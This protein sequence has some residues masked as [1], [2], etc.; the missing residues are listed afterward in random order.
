[1]KNTKAS[2]PPARRQAS[3]SLD[4]VMAY[5][6]VYA[7]YGEAKVR[8]ITIRRATFTACSSWYVTDDLIEPLVPEVW[9][10]QNF[11]EMD[12]D[13]SISFLPRCQ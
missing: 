3:F 10:G 8:I 2:I 6:G 12:E 5:P 4:H 1:M 9:A 11:L 7:P 13:V